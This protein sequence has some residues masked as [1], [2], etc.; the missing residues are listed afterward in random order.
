MKELIKLDVRRI[1]TGKTICTAHLRHSVVPIS[2]ADG[3]AI[4]RLLREKNE[5]QQIL[6]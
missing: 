2:D 1:D 5:G 3:D 4:E 6:L